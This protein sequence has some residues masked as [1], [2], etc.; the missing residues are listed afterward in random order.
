VAA[1][2]P[3]FDTAV[4][5]LDLDL[6]AILRPFRDQSVQVAS[7]V[8]IGC[9]Q[10]RA[11]FGEHGEDVARI[12]AGN[13]VILLR[14]VVDTDS[15]LTIVVRLPMSPG[16]AGPGGGRI[17]T[18]DSLARQARELS[19]GGSGEHLILLPSRMLDEMIVPLATNFGFR[20]VV[21]LSSQEAVQPNNGNAWKLQRTL[22]DHGLVGI[23]SVQIAGGEARCFLASDAVRSLHRVGL[24][25][26]G[27]V[28][29]SS[30]GTNG[31]F[32][33]QLFQYAYVKLYALRHGLNAA[34]P[35]WQGNQYFGLDD[36]S[37][38]DVALP[39]L[40]FGPFTDNDRVLWDSDDPPINI[41]LWG[42]F[43]EL[44]K[45]WQRHRPLLRRMFTL[46]TL[47]ERAIDAWRYDATLGGQ[48]TLV[49]VHV[50]RGDYRDRQQLD[51]P[52][53]RLVPEDWYLV[54][55]RAIWPMLRDPLLYVA[56]D[57]PDAILPIFQEFAPI[58][59]T[60]GP[61]ARAL[62][63]NIRDFEILRRADYLAICN[64]SFSRMAAILAPSTQKCFCPSFNAKGF[65][66]YEPWVDPGFWVRFTDA[67]R[68]PGLRMA[69]RIVAQSFKR[70]LVGQR[71]T[72]RAAVRRLAKIL[73][74]T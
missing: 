60:F 7:I 67:W 25:S 39:E 43:Q 2:S 71:D 11:D 23:G 15:G 3:T 74:N 18:L 50:R 31:Q 10:I 40:R 22:F 51:L 17:H 61:T 26:R 56:T 55:L 70:A 36:P 41:D 28:T 27:Q 52:W 38:A 16:E 44:P 20:A 1:G 47:H 53:F 5:Y 6:E 59:A 63:D 68:R 45:C 48:R 8:A 9:H 72:C 30:L 49:A 54:W 35:A 73:L 57:E 65:V 12:A 58:S 4:Q 66:P 19:N 29:M 46:S 14:L 32:A 69:P 21:A 64:S 13:D 37:P 62:P 24:G 42:Y 34:I 33:N